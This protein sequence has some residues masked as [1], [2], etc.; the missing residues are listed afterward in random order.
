MRV[1]QPPQPKQRIDRDSRFRFVSELITDFR[2]QHPIGYRYLDAT[3]KFDNQTHG[4]R[5]P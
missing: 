1:D 5:S 2:I 4:F 3:W